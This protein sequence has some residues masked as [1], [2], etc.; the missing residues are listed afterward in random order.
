MKLSGA[1]RTGRRVRL[2]RVLA[3]AMGARSSAFGSEHD[4]ERDQEI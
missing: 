4:D 1:A 3:M 2:V